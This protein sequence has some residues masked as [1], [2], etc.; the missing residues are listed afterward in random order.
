MGRSLKDKDLDFNLNKIAG[1]Y[2]H[3]QREKKGMSLDEVAKRVRTTRQNIYKYESNLSR[4]KL[5]MFVSICYALGLD[6]AT[7]YKEI[8]EILKEKG[9]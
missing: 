3:T 7:A 4:Q 6:P 2:L 8:I 9:F 1:E 5:N